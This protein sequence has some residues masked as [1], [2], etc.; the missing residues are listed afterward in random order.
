MSNKAIKQSLRAQRS[1]PE[2]FTAIK[3]LDRFATLAMTTFKACVLALTC[4]SLQA[5]DRD[6]TQPIAYKPPAV[7]KQ[8]HGGLKLDSLLI[9]KQRRHATIN[10]VQVKEG[11]R[12]AGARIAA[13]TS[14]GVTIERGGKKQ[15]LTLHSATVKN[16]HT[17][18]SRNG[19]TE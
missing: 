6:P 19:G 12:I 18:R 16:K 8:Q 14:Q 10:G 17:K 1:N 15:L 4:T 7:S 9:G 3:P 2:S 11:D 13:I 5:A